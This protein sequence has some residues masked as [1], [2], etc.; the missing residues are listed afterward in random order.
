MWILHFLRYTCVTLPSR[1]WKCPRQTMTSS[2][3]RIGRERTLYFVR[4]SLLRG[5]LMS[6]LRMW[7][8]A[9]KYALRDF[10][11]ELLTVAFCFMA[12]R[13]TPVWGAGKMYWPGLTL[14]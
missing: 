10:L 2:S 6:F 9:V 1:S 7:D 8:G 11:L 12:P 13:D 4:K 3:R 14:E 5:A